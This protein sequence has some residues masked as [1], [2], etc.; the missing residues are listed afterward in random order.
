MNVLN[1]RESGIGFRFQ[2]LAIFTPENFAKSA[3]SIKV[4]KNEKI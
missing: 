3:D 1:F 4:L 2:F